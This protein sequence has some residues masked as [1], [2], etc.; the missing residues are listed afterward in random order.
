MTVIGGPEGFAAG[1]G[2]A[3]RLFVGPELD[4]DGVVRM[5]NNFNKVFRSAAVFKRKWNEE[6]IIAHIMKRKK[7]EPLNALYYCTHYPDI[8]AAAQ[9]IFGSWRDAIEACGIDYGKVKKYREWTKTS[10]VEEI[11]ALAKKKQPLNSIHAQVKLKP[12]YMA[13]VKRFKSWAGAMKAAGIDYNK[14]R[15]RRLMSKSELRA[16]ILKRWNQHF[17]LAYPNMRKKCQWLL[18]SA[19]K[20]VGDGSW[21]KARKRCGI[22]INFRL[23]GKNREDAISKALGGVSA[24]PAKA[25]VKTV[26]VAAKKNVVKKSAPKKALPAK[27]AAVEKALPK[28]SAP[29][30]ILKAK[31]VKKTS[32]K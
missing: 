23:K 12:L 16:E 5:P 26:K 4:G 20:K 3:F 15:L 13:A 25:A 29:K 32:R 24:V 30:K 19:M 10:V 14:V 8:Y 22:K 17:D 2:L 7:V 1:M 18:A 21:D 27:K 28:K 31:A 6:L 11:K 9:R